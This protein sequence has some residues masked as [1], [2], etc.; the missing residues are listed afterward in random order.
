MENGGKVRQ[1]LAQECLI[2]KLEP[3]S[4]SAGLEGGP[5]HQFEKFTVVCIKGSIGGKADG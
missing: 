5:V 2:N 1:S 4:E 3:M